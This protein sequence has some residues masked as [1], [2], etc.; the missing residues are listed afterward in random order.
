MP[1]A[2]TSEPRWPR[3]GASAVV[4]RR[5]EVL[6]IERGKGPLKGLW[7]FPGGHVEPGEP[8]RAAALR[9]VAEETGIRAELGG[10]LDINEVLRKGADGGVIAHYLIVVFFGRWVAGEPVAG[11][12]AAAARFVALDAVD[13]LPTTDGAADFIRRAWARAAPSG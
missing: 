8:A 9:E 5:R 10:L 11:G 12:D 3:L 7:S 13:A 1:P 4:F 6:L 2:G